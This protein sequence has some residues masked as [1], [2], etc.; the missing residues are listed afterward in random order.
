MFGMGGAMDLV[1]GS[2]KVII[3]MEYCVKDGLVKIL[4]RCIMLFIA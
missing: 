2:R 3:V 4:R 1:I